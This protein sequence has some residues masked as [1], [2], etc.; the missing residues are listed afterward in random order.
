MVITGMEQVMAAVFRVPDAFTYGIMDEVRVEALRD[1]FGGAS[2][3]RPPI[4]VV[5]IIQG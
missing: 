3:R 4:V 2:Q 5:A 1:I